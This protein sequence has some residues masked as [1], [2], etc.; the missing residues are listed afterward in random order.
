VDCP[1]LSVQE[2]LRNRQ[3]AQQVIKDTLQKA[4]SRIKHQSDK[5]RTERKFEIGDMVYL[6]IQPYRHTSLSAHRSLKLHSKFYG[7]FRVLERIGNIAYKI[8]LPTGCQLHNVF[9]VIQ[10]KKH[11]GPKAVPS[12]ELPLID[13]KGTVKVAPMAILQRRMI[14]RDN[15]PVVQ[16]LVQWVN[17]PEAKATWEDAAFIQKV[18]P[19]FHP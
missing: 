19:S 8:L 12:T 15:E 18:F 3:V 16:W 2:Q 11:L 17:L 13:N 10:L 7:P 5:H 4:Q 1:D 6:K 14:P 9:H